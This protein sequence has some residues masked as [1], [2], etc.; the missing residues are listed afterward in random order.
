MGRLLS[1]WVD[2]EPR[3]KSLEIVTQVKAV[4]SE[5]EDFLPMT[6][7]QIFYRLVGSFSYP[8]QESNYK[9][10]CTILNRSR[11]AQMISF[12]AIRDDGFK[13]PLNRGFEDAESFWNTVEHAAR[14]YSR[15]KQDGQE[16]R[17]IFITEAAGMVPQIERVASPYS[18]PV[19]SSGG[20]DSLTTKRE[21]ANIADNE[22]MDECRPTVFLH[23][24]DYDPSGESIFEALQRDVTAFCERGGAAIFERIALTADQV[25]AFDLPTSPPKKSDTR[26][27]HMTETCQCEALSPADL[28]ELVKASIG[29]HF[30]LDTLA[31][32]QE[33][34]ER[35]RAEILERIRAFDAA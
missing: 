5:Y 6:I 14:S 19:I 24:G 23:I 20:F 32:V 35:E 7:R 10:L 16:Q 21:L 4:L 27:K 22:M 29:E 25:R 34:E 11:R 28:A 33:E 2:W 15:D 1:G 13:E 18:V 3:Q 12:D 17:L 8:K 30:C 9:A 26:A 31:G